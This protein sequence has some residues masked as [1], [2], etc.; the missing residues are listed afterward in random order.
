M[1]LGKKAFDH[2]VT[3]IKELDEIDE[4]LTLGDLD[5]YFDEK[6]FKKALKRYGYKLPRGWKAEL[7]TRPYFADRNFI[8]SQCVFG[9]LGLHQIRSLD[10]SKYEGSELIHDLNDPTPPTELLNR[11]QLIIDPGT[12]EHIFHVPN[13]LKAIGKMLTAGG[14]VVHQNPTSNYI[15]H[16]FY[17]FSPTFYH[18]YYENVDY[19]IGI[20][21]LIAHLADGANQ[22]AE[23]IALESPS[24][25]IQVDERMYA[26]F[27]WA[28]KG[29]D[30]KESG[31]PTQALYRQVWEHSNSPDLTKG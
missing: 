31:I 25:I 1:G 24:S 4:I 13:A 2:L 22:E 8:T 21:W 18:D 9:A 15:N 26:T 14:I 19:E 28:R 17:S 29:A 27:F 30:S 5:I 7:A 16:G 11:F 3:A 20:S 23:E 6:W 10:A 12:L